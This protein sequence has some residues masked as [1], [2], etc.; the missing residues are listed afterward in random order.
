MPLAKYIR[1]AWKENLIVL[2]WVVIGSSCTTLYGL[3]TAN[4]LT[5][6]VAFKFRAVII[7]VVVLLLT[8]VIWSLQI[9]FEAVTLTKSTQKMDTLI[10][11]D[12][13]SSLLNRSVSAFHEKSSSVYVS[14]LT[15]DISTINEFGFG[16]LEMALSQFLT[17]LMSIGAM[18]SFHYSMIIT[19]IVLSA[20]MLLAPKIFTAKM[21]QASLKATQAA[22]RATSKMSDFLL[23][24][25]ELVMINR[26]HLIHREITKASQDLADK[27]VKFAKASATMSASSNFTSLISQVILVAQAALLFFMHLVSAGAI[28]GARYF[29]ATI[30]ASLTGMIANLVEVGTVKPVFAKYGQLPEI[31]EEPSSVRMTPTA[32]LS[33]AVDGDAAIQLTDL[34]F[35]YPNKESDILHVLT[36]NF[37][38]AKK[39]ALVGESGSGKS[40]L[41]DLIAGK[42]DDYRGVIAVNGQDLQNMTPADL[43]K[44]LVYLN[45]K[46]HIFNESL[47]FNLTLGEPINKSS[48]QNVLF[49]SGLISL[50]DSLPEGL[51]TIISENGRNLSGGQQQ[52]IAIARGLIEQGSIWLVDEATSSLDRESAIQIEQTLF[53]IQDITLIIVTHQL[54]DAS[55]RLLDQIIYLKDVNQPVDAG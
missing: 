37:Q 21:N 53:K 46:P 10:R 34:S 42:H 54:H 50:I 23:G 36:L 51:D 12:I 14:W 3:S 19:I 13:T 30:F 22:E 28:S 32:N 33:N 8:S 25:D 41:L 45:Q 31:K 20:L 38:K 43:R 6:A 18:L 11:Q 44:Q 27:R 9:Y 15:N 35:S 55:S 39:Y 2:F 17:I 16:N 49:K 4:I 47:L 40:T 52:R 7:W 24:F 48:L 5:S 26:P 29:S 1:R